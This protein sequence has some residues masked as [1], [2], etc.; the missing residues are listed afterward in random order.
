MKGFFARACDPV[1]CQTH[2]LGALL[3]AVGTIFIV[4]KGLSP[5]TADLALLSGVIFGL[6]M[7]ALYSASSVYHYFSGSVSLKEYLRK[8][9]HAMIYVLIAGSYTP[10]CLNYMEPSVGIPFIRLLWVV[11]AGGILVKLLWINAPR[12]LSTLFYLGMGWSILLVGYTLKSIPPG[13]LFLIAAGGAAYSAGAVIYILK[14]P[15]LSQAFG[16]HEIFHVFILLGSAFHFAA[17]YC[18]IL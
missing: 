7:V 14:K 4:L 3:A 15:N 8:W 17:V 12:T 13:C 6:S 2:T 9:D 16:F 11:A 5:E 10:V 1:S 18:Y